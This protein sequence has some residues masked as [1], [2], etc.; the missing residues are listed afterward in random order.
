ME[1]IVI[2]GTDAEQLRESLTPARRRAA[3]TVPALQDIQDDGNLVVV[4]VEDDLLGEDPI[5]ELE[6]L[7]G[8]LTGLRVV[9][10]NRSKNLERAKL[11]APLGSVLPLPLD[12]E[13]LDLALRQAFALGAMTAE[14]RTI[15]PTGRS[16][17]LDG[18]PLS[19]RNPR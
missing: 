13:R 11:L 5:A 17:T 12:P 16:P 1:R 3:S 10:I 9:F 6:R 7:R 2:V 14:M 8:R 4:V 19:K 15:R 18:R